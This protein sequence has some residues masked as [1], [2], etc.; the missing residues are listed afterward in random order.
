MGFKIEKYKITAY[1]CKHCGAPTKPGKE[2]CDWCGMG[3]ASKYNPIPEKY[4]KYLKKSVR[5]LIDA[6]ADFIYFDSVSS[7]GGI[8]TEPEEIEV[9]TLDSSS[10]NFVLGREIYTP[11]WNFTMPYTKRGLE[12]FNKLDKDKTYN[13]RLELLD[14]DKAFEMSIKPQELTPMAISQDCLMECEVSFA[15]ERIDGFKDLMT[16]DTMTCPNCGAPVKS[17]YG[18]CDFCSGWLEYEF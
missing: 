5:V 13:M 1:H 10:Q 14:I 8:C 18:A 17:H 7:V 12:L 16:P 3:I 11:S 4:R 6:G 2:L 9:T 15:P